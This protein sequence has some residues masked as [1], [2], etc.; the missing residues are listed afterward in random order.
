MATGAVNR[1]DFIS[2][3]HD[4]PIGKTLQAVAEN[5]EIT[6]RACHI[7]LQKHDTITL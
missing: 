5:L 6:D 4:L 3:E 1:D 7:V 2:G